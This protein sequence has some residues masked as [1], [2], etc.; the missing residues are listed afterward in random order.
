M[1]LS[2][3]HRAEKKRKKNI[4]QVSHEEVGEMETWS[5]LTPRFTSRTNVCGPSSSSSTAGGAM[6][7]TKAPWCLFIKTP[8]SQNPTAVGGTVKIEHSGKPILIFFR[9]KKFL[10]I[11]QVFLPPEY[12]A[13]KAEH[14]TIRDREAE[15][16]LSLN[17]L[18]P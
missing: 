13:N 10:K 6:Q 1:F 18:C 11:K 7:A 17:N 8:L 5:F 4:F 15:Y 9:K 12:G 14:Y 2:G 16:Y 3:P